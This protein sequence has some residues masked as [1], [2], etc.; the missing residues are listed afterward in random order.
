MLNKHI[1][2]CLIAL[3]ITEMQNKSTIRLSTSNVGNDV[4]Q[5][6]FLYDDGRI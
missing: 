1:R 5:S 2:K 4:E 3:V 6:E